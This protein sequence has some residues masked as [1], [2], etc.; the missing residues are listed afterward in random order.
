MAIYLY[1]ALMILFIISFGYIIKIAK[2]D[3]KLAL[4]YLLII[5]LTFGLLVGIIIISDYQFTDDLVNT[6][7]TADNLKVLIYV[8]LIITYVSII[9]IP[10]KKIYNKDILVKTPLTGDKGQ[11]GNRGSQGGSGYCNKCG[12]GDLCYKKMLYNITLTYNWWREN[13]KKLPLLPDSYIIKNEYLKS[14]IKNHCKSD[15]FSK[16][17]KKFGSNN[18]NT[19]AYDYMFRMWTI[20]ILIILKYDKGSL[21]L[22]SEQLTETDFVN[23]IT[24]KDKIK[25]TSTPTTTSTATSTSPW[26]DMFDTNGTNVS[27]KKNLTPGSDDAESYFELKQTGLNIDFLKKPGVPTPIG[28]PFDEIKKYSAWYWGSK[29][30]SKPIVDIITN[31]DDSTDADLCRTCMNG[32]TNFKWNGDTV[33]KPNKKIKIKTTNTFYKLFSTDNAG[34][35]NINEIYTP[36]QPFGKNLNNHD[37]GVTFLRPYEYVDNDE[38]PKFRNYKPVGDILI[39]SDQLSNSANNSSC[40]PNDLKYTRKNINKIVNEDISS[41]LVSGDVVHPKSFTKVYTSINT[42]GVNKNIT[43]FTVWKPNPPNNNYVALGYVID[44]TPYKTTDSFGKAISPTPNPTPP[45]TDIMVCVPKDMSKDWNADVDEIWKN[46]TPYSESAID[47]EGSPDTSS[48]TLVKNT[49]ESKYP[50]NTFRRFNVDNHNSIK[51][52]DDTKLTDLLCKEYNPY[53]DGGI[54]TETKNECNINDDEENLCKA[55]HK[56]EFIGAECNYKK[57]NIDDLIKYSILKIYK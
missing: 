32:C 41:I 9:Q 46:I 52:I 30:N 45:S 7:I 24:E 33:A 57:P 35:T 5:T 48:I 38:H 37:V 39:G 19:G 1:L 25:D 56:C 27:I 21:F 40:K 2:T 10:V 44:T 51:Q 50:L 28:T 11:R 13:V 26:D 22:E 17:L 29:S 12:S 47:L 14:K 15:E 23:M 49:T 53:K 55:N 36:F 31:I 54:S 42:K 6:G 8:V 4:L 16:I 20:W 34:Q 3:I 43:A 18:D